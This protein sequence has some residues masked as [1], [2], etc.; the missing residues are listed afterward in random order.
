MAFDDST[1]SGLQCAPNRTRIVVGRWLLVALILTVFGLLCA[2]GIRAWSERN[3][4]PQDRL[5]ASEE[6][7]LYAPGSTL[8]RSGGR[9]PT[10][11]SSALVHL[12]L[13]TEASADYVL[14]FYVQELA[15]RG[16]LTGGG[17]S[18]IGV[19]FESQVCA[20]HDGSRILRLSF[21]RQDRWQEAYPDDPH[22][23]VYEI[24]LIGR[25]RSRTEPACWKSE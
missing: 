16:W 17:S 5:W 23:T 10:F 1:A 19:D 25:T 22:V 21:W 8:L 11:E 6:A 20:W 7:S 2:F 4:T 13:A 24:A 3:P 12:Q 14:A 9:G 15:A 18:V